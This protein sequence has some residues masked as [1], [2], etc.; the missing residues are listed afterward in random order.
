M[1][2]ASPTASPSTNVSVRL[3]SRRKI[4]ARRD[5][6]RQ[7]TNPEP[8]SDMN[9]FLDAL[10]AGENVLVA[11]TVAEEDSEIVGWAICDWFLDWQIVDVFVRP[12]RRKQG[13]G[14]K[15]LERL[16]EELDVPETGIVPMVGPGFHWTQFPV[17]TF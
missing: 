11:S 1:L 5:V 7:L 4:L 13:I 16:F 8:H 14:T 2:S 6:L 15:L 3:Q 17:D 9:R 10:G 12:D